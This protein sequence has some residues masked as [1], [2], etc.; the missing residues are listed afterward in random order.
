MP[1]DPVDRPA[2]PRS[3]LL[4]L[5][6]QIELL[7]R[8]TLLKRTKRCGKKGCPCAQDPARRH[9][10]YYEW[11]RME[12]GRLVHTMVSPAQARLIAGAI[13]DHKKIQRLLRRWERESTKGILRSEDHSQ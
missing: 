7:S 3:E 2:S 11:G 1:Q 13:R 5:L 10:P 8:G 4:K 6:R 9:G 12:A